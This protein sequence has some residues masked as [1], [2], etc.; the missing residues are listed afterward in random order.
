MLKARETQVLAVVAVPA[1]ALGMVHPRTFGE[2]SCLPL[3]AFLVMAEFLLTQAAVVV[4]WPLEGH[5]SFR[6]TNMSSPGLLEP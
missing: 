4:R 5:Q 3:G 2:G 1:G 6:A